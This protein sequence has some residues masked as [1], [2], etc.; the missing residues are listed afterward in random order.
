MRVVTFKIEDDLL[1]LIDEYAK[2]NRMTRTDVIR[3]AL[4]KF[5]REELAKEVLQTAKVEKIKL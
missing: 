3:T 2:K 5:V 4:T 1:K